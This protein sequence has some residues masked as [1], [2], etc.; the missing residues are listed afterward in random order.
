M[1]QEPDIDIS[2]IESI[3]ELPIPVPREQKLGLLKTLNPILMS[4]WQYR[5]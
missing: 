4:F 1:P 2:K 5:S 3:K